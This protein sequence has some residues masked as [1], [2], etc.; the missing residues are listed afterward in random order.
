[1]AL[2]GTPASDTL[3]ARFDRDLVYGLGGRDFLSSAGYNDT[4]L[5]GGAGNDQLRSW[6]DLALVPGV[7]PVSL[8]ATQSGGT[9]ND[10]LSASIRGESDPE[11]VPE[12]DAR[13]NLTGGVGI[14]RIAVNI[15][16]AYRLDARIS[17]WGG[18]DD[19][20][21][22][23][24]ESDHVSSLATTK[25]TVRAGAGNDQVTIHTT[26]GFFDVHNNVQGEKGNDTIIAEAI[27]QE[28]EGVTG[29]SAVNEISGG[30][31]DDLIRATAHAWTGQGYAV[32]GSNVISGDAGNDTIDANSW[33]DNQL[34]G[35]I[36][37]DVIIGTVE[38]DNYGTR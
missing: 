9:G 11:R 25:H 21:V 10:T 8:V 27:A 4:Y 35:G 5:D 38:K 7:E 29:G 1:M 6:F 16:A 24:S 15:S 31:D 23:V 20:V 36:G 37:S 2:N 19:D 17:I 13:L 3:S 33:G 30:D 14:D 34:S 18:A 28:W 32:E 12:I 26:G 22:T